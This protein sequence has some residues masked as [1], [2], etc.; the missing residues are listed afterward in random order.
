MAIVLDDEVQ[1]SPVIE[2]AITGGEGI[3][4][5]GFS[6]RDASDLALLLEAGALPVSMTFLGGEYVGPTLGRNSVE[7]G[8]IASLGGLLLAVVIGVPLTVLLYLAAP[9]VYPYLRSDPAVIAE[10][11]P[12]LRAR[13]IAVVGAPANEGFALGIEQ[14]DTDAWPVG[15]A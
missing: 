6:T 8:V 11:V 14:H 7:A 13:L 10:C 15:Q 2:S 3:I 12:Y 9:I 4:R 5:G 1:S